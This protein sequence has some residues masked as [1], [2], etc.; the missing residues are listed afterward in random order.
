VSAR[1][2]A[3]NREWLGLTEA[4]ALL[5]VSATTVRRWSDA[6]QLNVFTTPGGHR[7]FSRSALER[8]VS[9]DRQ[10]RPALSTAGVT[11]ARL[12]RTYR[13]RASQLAVDAPWLL[14]LTDGQRELFRS[15]GR[16]VA[17]SLLRYLDEYDGST[18]EQLLEEASGEAA[19][20]GRVAA[21]LGFSL[22]QTVEGFLRFRAPFLGELAAVARR[23]GFDTSATTDLLAGAER[24]LDRL[25]LA[26]MT[27]HAAFT[28]RPGRKSP[29]AIAPDAPSGSAGAA[30]SRAESV[31]P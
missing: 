9:A 31:A 7:R 5:G 4:S 18:R 1:R 23:R 8:L 3:R 26:A 10:R 15:H 17:A 25:L 20:Y 2:A 19:E 21:S 12:A 11:P 30:A 24:G 16:T 22:S 27:G 28:R 14:R 13:R 6:G 29:D